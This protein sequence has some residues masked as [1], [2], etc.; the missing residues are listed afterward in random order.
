[1]RLGETGES[2]NG[3]G[4]SGRKVQSRVGGDIGD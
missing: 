2:G 3:R 1:M 4:E